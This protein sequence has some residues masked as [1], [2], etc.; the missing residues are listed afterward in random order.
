MTQWY[1]CFVFLVL[2]LYIKL[3][4]L[5][6]LIIIFGNDLYSKTKRCVLRSVSKYYLPDRLYVKYYMGALYFFFGFLPS[7]A[8]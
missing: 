5:F 4:V 8:L 2:K 7:F 1:L 3:I 6:S